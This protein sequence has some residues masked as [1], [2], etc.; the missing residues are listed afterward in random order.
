MKHSDLID[1]LL[2]CAIA[3]EHCSA[4]CL[5]EEHFLM[6]RDCIRLDRGCADVCKLTASLLA[7]DS[8][9]GIHLLKECAEVCKKCAE[10]CGTHNSSHCL[11]CATACRTCADLCLAA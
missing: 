2:K 10:E 1:A 7:R 6:M 4:S 8:Q 9:H 5:N 3:C 11:E